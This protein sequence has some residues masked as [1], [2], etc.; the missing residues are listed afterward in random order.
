MKITKDK[1]LHFTCCMLIAL[2]VTMI[3]GMMSNWYVGALAGLSTAMGTGV[4]KEYGDAKSPGNKWDWKDILADLV[5]A[6]VGIV[7]G[8]IIVLI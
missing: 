6:A 2:V 7:I 8:I 1:W 5:G 3:L 4:G